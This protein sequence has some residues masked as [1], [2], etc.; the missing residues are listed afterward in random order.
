MNEAEW[1]VVDQIIIQTDSR[2][3]KETNKFQN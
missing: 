3:M 2:N 1:L